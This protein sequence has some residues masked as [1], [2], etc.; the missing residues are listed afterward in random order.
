[1]Q[2]NFSS[3]SRDYADRLGED[4]LGRNN[5]FR[6]LIDEVG[7]VPG[8]DIIFGSDGMP[9]GIAYAATQSLFPARPG[10]ALSLD[11]LVAGYG[12]A[13]GVSGSI[14]LEIDEAAGTVRATGAAADGRDQD[15]E[16]SSPNTVAVKR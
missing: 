4:Y 10:Q 2:P 5:P 8:R 16:P 11:E 13:R 15:G 9:D 3:D 6:M 1:M 7:F 14:A 12:T